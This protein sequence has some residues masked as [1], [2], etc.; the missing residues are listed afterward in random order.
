MSLTNNKRKLNLD[1]SEPKRRL[2]EQKTSPELHVK[3]LDGIYLRYFTE[4]CGTH[5]YDLKKFNGDMLGE[6]IY[7]SHLDDRLRYIVMRD[8]YNHEIKPLGLKSGTN[9]MS[10]NEHILHITEAKLEECVTYLKECLEL[11]KPNNIFSKKNLTIIGK[12]YD[13]ILKAPITYHKLIKFMRH[14]CSSDNYKCD[15]FGSNTDT[16]PDDGWMQ[17]A[18]NL[19]VYDGNLSFKLGKQ[20]SKYIWSNRLKLKVTKASSADQMVLVNVDKAQWDNDKVNIFNTSNERFESL[21]GKIYTIVAMDMGH[22]YCVRR[23]SAT[24]NLHVFFVHSDDWT[25]GNTEIN[26]YWDFIDGYN[27]ANKN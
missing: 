19:Y 1:E 27:Y 20:D 2:C 23:D 17:Y 13:A 6:I 15:N 24:S 14:A 18:R 26:K 5:R 8:V 4:R 11:T 22:M 10:N 21:D 7:S 3:Q 16:Y 25:H 12:D 9:S